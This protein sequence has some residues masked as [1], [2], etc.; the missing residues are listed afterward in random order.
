MESASRR[1]KPNDTE[2][3]GCWRITSRV[4]SLLTNNVE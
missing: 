3:E 2:E 1:P 4:R